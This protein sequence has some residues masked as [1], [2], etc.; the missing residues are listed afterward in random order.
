M[1][2]TRYFKLNTGRYDFLSFEDDNG[3]ISNV[4][5]YDGRAWTNATEFYYSMIRSFFALSKANCYGEEITQEQC[6]SLI[7]KKEVL[8]KQNQTTYIRLRDKN[9]T[10]ISFES[11]KGCISNV[12]VFEDNQWKLASPFYMQL[13]LLA[14]SRNKLEYFGKI[15][16][17]D[18]CMCE[19]AK[20]Q[21]L[22][23]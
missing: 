5:C 11:N 23:K 1:A 14:D 17:K 16:T 6:E 8:K 4:K 3:E 9:S 10:L 19:I 15:L 21:D 2:K 13:I 22:N 20:N 12:Q 18:E 7:S